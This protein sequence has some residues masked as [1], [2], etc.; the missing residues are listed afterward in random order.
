MT[1]RSLALSRYL[2]RVFPIILFAIVILFFSYGEVNGSGRSLIHNPPLMVPYEKLPLKKEDFQ[3]IEI[4][5]KLISYFD[6]LREDNP[7]YQIALDDFR[8]NVFQVGDRLKECMQKEGKNAEF[9]ELWYSQFIFHRL[10]SQIHYDE[11]KEWANK[12]KNNPS[13]RHFKTSTAHTSIRSLPFLRARMVRLIPEA[14]TDVTVLGEVVVG[15]Y[16]D[17][18]KTDRWYLVKYQNDQGFIPAPLL[19]ADW[20]KQ[21]IQQGCGLPRQREDQFG[22]DHIVLHYTAGGGSAEQVASM[23]TCYKAHYYVD[24]EGNIVQAYHDYELAHHAGF[25]K[26]QDQYHS[27]VEGWHNQ[28]SIGIEI[29]NYGPLKLGEEGFENLYNR[30]IE[31]VQDIKAGPSDIQ[32]IWQS[33]DNWTWGGENLAKEDYWQSYELVKQY[34]AVNNLLAYLEERYNIPHQSF[35]FKPHNESITNTS[36]YGFYYFPNPQK[37]NEIKDYYKGLNNFRGIIG[38]H[39]ATGKVDPGPVLDLGK[40]GLKL[41]PE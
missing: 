29:V 5:K 19:H 9:C 41:I 14:D 34:T 37:T 15:D 17:Y 7:D 18:Y 38:H 1:Y 32:K 24:R 33:E 6:V 13:I 26:T 4:L 35:Y 25:S 31:D 28:N 40:D 12:Q 36:K 16:L 23:Q 10:M 3:R 2:P 22:I 21:N 30:P 20:I 8:R 11:R 27:N 39:N